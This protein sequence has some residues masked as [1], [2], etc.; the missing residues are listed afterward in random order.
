MAET[1]T[2]A[3]PYAEALFRVATESSGN[4]DAWSELVS[5]MGHVAANPDMKAVAGDP[6]MHGDKLSALFLS[7]LKSP[8][9]D[10]AKRFVSL[11]VANHRLSVLPEIA[12]QFLANRHFQNAAGALDRVAFR[13]VFILAQHHGA[14]R[15][16]LEVQ[17]ETERV[18][19]EFQHLALH[20][21]GQAVHAADTIGHGNY[22]AGVAH[23][24]VGAKTR[25]AG[26][27]QL[28]D[29]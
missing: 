13:N 11:L 25:D 18:A 9:N 19:G 3:R 12:E 5:E 2:I 7:A 29:F 4:L 22:R 10:E 21:A 23:F 8:V 14:D 27:D 15:V 28:A 24:S 20:H 1:A 26:L 16:A 17:C 6:N